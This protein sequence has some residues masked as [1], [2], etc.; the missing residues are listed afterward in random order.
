MRLVMQQHNG[1]RTARL[2]VSREQRAQLA[3]QGIGGRQ[4]V[5]SSTRRAHRGA[6][7]APGAHVGIDGNMV[8]G[9]RDRTGGAEVEAAAAADNARARMRAELLREFD[10]ARLV[11][12]ADEIARLEHGAQRARRVLGVGAQIAV[13]QV[14]RGE[15]RRATGEIDDTIT[16]PP[17]GMPNVSTPREEGAG[18]A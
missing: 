1:L 7:A 5:G 13:A 8:S 16:A 4:R 10:V 3:Q 11:E 18:A 15:Q 12:R 14:M 17:R 9:G 6:L 2:R